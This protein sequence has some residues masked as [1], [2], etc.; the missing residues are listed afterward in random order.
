MVF[1]APDAPRH[2]S[3]AKVMRCS[4]KTKLCNVPKTVHNRM[5]PLTAALEIEI[6]CKGLVSAVNKH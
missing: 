5:Y 6:N 3:V 1:W 4:R 2:V